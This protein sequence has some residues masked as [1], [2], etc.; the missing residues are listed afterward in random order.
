MASSA[1]STVPDLS[2]LAI[3]DD[4]NS[5]HQPNDCA[6]AL[7]TLI[8]N[9]SQAP[10]VNDAT[11]HQ[12]ANQTHKHPWL[13]RLTPVIE[14]LAARDHAGNFV[15]TRGPNPQKT[16]E[17]MPIYAL[18]G[19][20]LLFV[21][22]R[23]Y[24]IA[25]WKRL[26]AQ[27]KAQSI[28]QG[29]LFDSESG[30]QEHIRSF[31]KT[32]NLQSTLDQLLK[33]DPTDYKTF[34]EFFYR[35]LKPGARP[36]TSPNDPSVITSAA[37]C[38][39]TVF[40]DISIAK[41]FWIKGEQF[42]V[43]NLIQDENLANMPEFKDGGCI[44]IFRLAPADY[45]RF[46]SPV[47]ATLGPV[48]HIEGQ[49]F[50][51]NPQAVNENFNV[52]TENRRDVILLNLPANGSAPPKPVIFVAVGAMLVGSIAWSLKQGDEVKKADELGYFAYGG[53]TV[54]CLF[55]K[56][57]VTFDADL[58]KNSLAHMETLVHVGEQIGKFK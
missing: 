49:Y 2:S 8:D 45:H 28:K 48:K 22:G 44:A 7:N 54:I 43:P 35:K 21:T 12:L 50:T 37:D 32:Y 23:H 24:G 6:V 1:T 42:N 5:E 53:S 39:L 30:A 16:F 52:F 9:T 41:E 10:G 46:H 38:R 13:N 58:V 36:A 27:M 4:P 34:N 26:E 15:M 19:M 29:K 47:T 57:S 31:I 3:T 25:E 11:I 18:I 40:E 51:V 14:K 55:P 17:S 33:P 20:H 56:N